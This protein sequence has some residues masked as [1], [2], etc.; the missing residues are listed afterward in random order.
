MAANKPSARIKKYGVCLNDKCEKYKQVQ[1]IV[2]GEYTCECGKKMSPCA[3]PKKG[4]GR[5]PVYVAI[6]A[7]AAVGIIAGVVFG[8][9]NCG[10]GSTEPVDE[11]VVV[12]SDS[13]RRAQQDALQKAQEDSLKEALQKAQ[14]EL[15]K[16]HADSLLKVRED[17]LLKV[18]ED[19][20]QKA[21]E[22]SIAKA[23]SKSSSRSNPSYGTVNLGYGKYTGDLKNGK[24]HG[25]GTITYTRSRQI[26]SSKDFI[27]SPGDKLEGRFENGQLVGMGHWYH[28]GNVTTVKE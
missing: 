8:V 17:S 23:K 26:V 15:L 18:R 19:S 21:R 14:D 22:D 5:K 20:I 13:I 1:E 28:G 4:N 27:A 25:R 24:P 2:H 10:G 12:D 3:P 11:P 7:I 6:A 16:M 9:R